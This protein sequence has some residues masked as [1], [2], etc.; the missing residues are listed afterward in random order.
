MNELGTPTMK[1]RFVDLSLP[2]FQGMQTFPVHWHPVVR[3]T[4]LGTLEVEHR[5]TRE[6]LLGTHTGTHCDAPSHFISK[7]A[8]IDEIPLETL[9][10]PAF[11]IDFSDAKPFQQIEIADLE[12]KLGKRKPDRI[13]IR[14]DWS[15][16]VGTDIYYSDHPFLS[17][18]AASWLVERG[19]KL[20]A[21]DTP[22]PDNPIHGFGC[23]IDSPI[24]KIVLGAGVIL[25]EYLCNLRSLPAGDIE[26]IIMPLKIVGGDGSPVRAVGV[27]ND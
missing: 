2:V 20:I 8:T 27:V 10:G 26:L 13:V 15:D 14:Y 5:E 22:M 23:D 16:H 1:S 7:G 3:I 17:E 12:A 4:V 19:V 18:E 25:V 6:L 9:I 21:M 11:V 24:H